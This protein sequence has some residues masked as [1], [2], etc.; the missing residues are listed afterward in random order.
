[1]LDHLRIPVS[2][3]QM[4][5]RHVSPLSLDSSRL[6]PRSPGEASPPD[7][8]WEF[9][10]YFPTKRRSPTSSVLWYYLLLRYNRYVASDILE[11]FAPSAVTIRLCLAASKPAT[12]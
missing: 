4:A 5:C 12:C 9:Q 10:D 1:M 8:D 11:R 7:T 2:A 6:L 3:A